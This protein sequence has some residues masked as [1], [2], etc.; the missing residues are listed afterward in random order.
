[1]NDF[2]IFQ[3]WLKTGPQISVYI[4][5]NTWALDL[6]TRDKAKWE[7]FSNWQAKHKLIDESIGQDDRTLSKTRRCGWPL[8]N[9]LLGGNVFYNKKRQ[10]KLKKK[11][12]RLSMANIW[13]DNKE[14][15]KPMTYKTLDIRKELD[16]EGTQVWSILEICKHVPL[17][18]R[19]V[20]SPVRSPH[21][22]KPSVTKRG[23]TKVN[24]LSKVRPSSRIVRIK[25][26]ACHGRVTT[27]T[28]N[29]TFG[30]VTSAPSSLKATTAITL[31]MS[32]TN[33]S[34]RISTATTV[35]R[36]GRRCSR[37]TGTRSEGRS[38]AQIKSWAVR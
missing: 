15:D 1:M 17:L 20:P 30:R 11:K 10:V 2:H 3:K 27:T 14:E 23:W 28:T 18:T 16:I 12:T 8:K 38:S 36:H 32:T 24:R 19:K 25:T 22:R 33:I 21:F 35:H 29:M 9:N 13:T 26:K 5:S 31:R 34:R 7:D 6:C 37:H 4:K